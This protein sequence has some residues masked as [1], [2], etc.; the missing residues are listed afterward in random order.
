VSDLQVLQAVLEAKRS[1][2]GGVLATIIRD[3]GSV[4]RHAG[5]KMFVYPSGSIIGTIG[6]GDMEHRVISHALLLTKPDTAHFELIDPKR[7]D[8]GVCG[9]QVDIF[10]EPIRPDPTVLVIGCGHCGQAL[11]D[12]AHWAGFRVIVSDDRAELCTPE[13]IPNADEYLVIPAKEIASKAP[14]HSQTYIAAVTRGMSVDLEMLPA[15][16]ETPAP[17]IGVMG[18]RRRWATAVKNLKARGITEAALKR[19]YAPI[20]IELNAESPREIAVS[21]MA[22]IIAHYRGGSGQPM[23]WMGIPE[24]ASDSLGA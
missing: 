14:I 3:Q 18:S 11:A 17:Y 22:E 16:L 24:E 12:L 20:G 15:L 8:P 5:T 2:S 9:G 4:P 19:I 1:G 21:I 10:M 6:G 13:A 7:G 23:K